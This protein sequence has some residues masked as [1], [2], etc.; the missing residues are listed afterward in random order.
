MIEKICDMW[1]FDCPIHGNEKGAFCFRALQ[2]DLKY[3][4]FKCSIYAVE[5]SEDERNIFFSELKEQY[6]GVQNEKN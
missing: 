4:W 6:F 5:Y 2:D 1:I 3:N